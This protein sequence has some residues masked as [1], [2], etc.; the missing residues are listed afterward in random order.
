MTTGDSSPVHQE[1]RLHMPDSR[2]CIG[3][4]NRPTH[5]YLIQPHDVF[6]TLRYIEDL[7]SHDVHQKCLNYR[8]RAVLT[9]Q[10][11]I[12]KGIAT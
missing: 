5:V 12:L 10:S 7:H 6:N 11:L 8:F 4:I 1:M 2:W 9:T 3:S